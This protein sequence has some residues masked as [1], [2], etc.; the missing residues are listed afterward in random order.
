MPLIRNQSTSTV[1]LTLSRDLTR[2]LRR[3]HPWVFADALKHTPDGTAGAHAALSDRRGKPIARG[4]YDPESPLAFRACTVTRKGYLDDEW[5]AAQLE[6]AVQLRDLLIDRRITTGYRLFNGEGDGLPGL[7][8]DVYGD[9]AVLKLDGPAPEGFWD[10]KGIAEWVSERLN[11][12]RVYQRDRTRTGPQGRALVGAAPD[13]PVQFLEHGLRFAADV[14]QGQKTGF[15]LD[16][17]ENRQLI[18]SMA[19]G[20]QTL[21]VFGYTGGFS[22]YAGAGGATRVTTVDI[23]KPAIA[24]SEANMAL[25]GLSACHEA[26]AED[27]FAF[28]EGAAEAKRSWDLVIL[29]PPSFAPNRQSADRAGSAYERLVTAGARV[30]APGGL[31]AA[32]SCS[33]HVGLEAFTRHVENG[34][35]GA[36]RRAT[37]LGIHQQPSDHPTPLPFQDFR[38][39]KLLLLRLD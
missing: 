4:F 27:A 24:A 21:N 17:R 13:A 19:A 18:R 16:Q 38:Y 23:A 34:V 8:V 15:F 2:S 29:D 33:S 36:R 11:L 1:R 10:A 25:N 31:L 26:V 5:A 3:G 30:T 7:V 39:L 14:V 20:R 12:S 28:L 6:H 35:G 9:T 32:A 37:V 22:V